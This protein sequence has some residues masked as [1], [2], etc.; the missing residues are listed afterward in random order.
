MSPPKPQVLVVD[1][2]GDACANLHDILTDCGY[3]V[4]TAT[5]GESALELINDLHFD[6]ALLDLKL[7]GIDGLQLFREIQ[8]V[9]AGTSVLILSAYAA[10][11]SARLALDAGARGVLEKPVRVETLLPLLRSA[12]ASSGN[13][14]ESPA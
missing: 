8:R 3:S 6:A 12:V 13:T 9:S 2:D 4:A 7:P 14:A 1:D 10:A 11:D 5:S